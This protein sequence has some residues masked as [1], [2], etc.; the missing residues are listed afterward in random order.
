MQG[1]RGLPDSE[2]GGGRRKRA[3]VL[4]SIGLDPADIAAEVGLPLDHVRKEIR[5]VAPRR[6]RLVGCS[7]AAVILGVSRPTGRLVGRAGIHPDGTGVAARTVVP[8]LHPPSVSRRL[9]V[10]RW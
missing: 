10:R 9:T 8:R 2:P 3:R 5:G 7:G 1:R 4:T 6:H